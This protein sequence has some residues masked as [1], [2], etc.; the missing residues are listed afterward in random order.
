MR[1]ISKAVH[2]N[3]N[4]FEDDDRRRARAYGFVSREKSRVRLVVRARSL[5]CKRP[6]AD[7]HPMSPSIA[8][9]ATPSAPINIMNI[10]IILRDIL[11]ILTLYTF[12]LYMVRLI[13]RSVHSTDGDH[14]ITKPIRIRIIDRLHGLYICSD[15]LVRQTL[16]VIVYKFLC[17][18]PCIVMVLLYGIILVYFWWTI[19]LD[20][21]IMAKSVSCVAAVTMM[22]V[23]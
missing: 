10:H 14:H 17:L 18:S 4:E 8:A 2:P 11:I 3:D 12:A 23:S 13:R 22:M 9:R 20:T 16:T 6:T 1:A 7:D 21:I 5:H 19:I 15:H